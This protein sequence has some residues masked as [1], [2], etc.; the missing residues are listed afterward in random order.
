M[1]SSDPQRHC[2]R[3]SSSILMSIIKIRKLKNWKISLH[4]FDSFV[5]HHTIVNITVIGIL[6]SFC[7]FIVSYSL[8][9]DIK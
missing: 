1:S 7:R 9:L 3:V 8:S 6:V 4:V 5:S 2:L